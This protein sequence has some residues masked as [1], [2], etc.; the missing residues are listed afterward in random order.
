MPTT[1][2]QLAQKTTTIDTQK[3]SYVLENHPSGEEGF[4][5]LKN[6]PDEPMTTVEQL[7]SAVNNYRQTHGL[8]TIFIDPQLCTIA[9]QRAEEASKHFSHDGFQEHIEN[10]DYNFTGFQEIGENLW[11]GSF[12]G[13]HI[14]EFGLG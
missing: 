12:S 4:Y 5:V 11:Q 6:T 10:G 1:V 7:N 13:V 9:N 14:V 3:E 8:N 2:P